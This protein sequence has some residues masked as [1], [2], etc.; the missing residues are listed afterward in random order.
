M[1]KLSKN[2]LISKKI[3]SINTINDKKG[4]FFI[5]DIPG[6]EYNTFCNLTDT[7][8][9]DD[10]YKESWVCEMSHMGIFDKNKGMFNKI[11]MYEELKNNKYVSFDSAYDYI[12]VPISEKETIETIL[13]KANL[14]CKDSQKSNNLKLSADFRHRM[15]EE[16]ITITCKTSLEELK[17]KNRRNYYN[18][19]NKSW[20]IKK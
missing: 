6:K 9:L 1:E 16:E 14:N 10:T 8:K 11:N 13:S 19:Q 20:R 2:K 7:D 17:S 3:F 15:R 12:S 4:M 5:G 18:L